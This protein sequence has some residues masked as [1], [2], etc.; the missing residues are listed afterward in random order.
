V[1][2]VPVGEL[3]GGPGLERRVAHVGVR[4]VVDREDL[5]AG[6]FA[7]DQVADVL[8]AG[9]LRAALAARDHEL[10][11]VAAVVA[12]GVVAVVVAQRPAGVERVDE[13]AVQLAAVAL[14]GLG[15][16]LVDAVEEVPDDLVGDQQP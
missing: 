6:G 14:A 10:L 1:G 13:R 2:L 11:Q 4:V 16:A 9:Q 12:P 8:V 3:P 15:A 7:R 5:R